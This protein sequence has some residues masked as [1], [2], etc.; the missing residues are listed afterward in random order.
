MTDLQLAW[1]KIIDKLESPSTKIL[2][3]QCAKLIDLDFDK[4]RAIIFVE[5][6]FAL[7][8]I[9]DSR[10][11]KLQQAVS[12]EL[13]ENFKA[14]LTDNQSLPYKNRYDEDLDSD[15]SNSVSLT[16]EDFQERKLKILRQIELSNNTTNLEPLNNCRFKDNPIK[17]KNLNFRSQSEVEIAEELD[18]RGICFFPNSALRLTTKKGRENKEPDFFV[19]YNKKS[20]ILEVDGISHTPERRVE[21]QERE[22]DFER[23]GMRIFRFDSNKCYNN[24][25][26]VVDEFLEILNNI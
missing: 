25:S 22:R 11:S 12:E 10:Y 8:K 15:S 5:K 2:F 21:E 14:I 6:Y 13:G 26:L 20:A 24:P 3:Q 1:Q 17:W 19:L 18:K 4:K 16:V 23:N 9:I 7:K